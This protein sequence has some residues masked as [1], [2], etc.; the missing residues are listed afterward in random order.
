V[1]ML[2]WSLGQAGLDLSGRSVRVETTGAGE[3]SWHW[4]LGSREIPAKTHIPDAELRGRAPQLALVAAKRLSADDVL[5][6]GAVVL[7]GD[8]G[9]AEIVLRNLRAFP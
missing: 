5:G 3:G 4:G 6:S 1:R 7:G 8:P 9:L 2:P